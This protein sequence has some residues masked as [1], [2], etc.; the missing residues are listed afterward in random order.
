MICGLVQGEE[1]KSRWMEG[2]C[3]E[4]VGA[5][6]NSLISYNSCNF[7]VI[8]K[9][10]IQIILVILRFHGSLS[11]PTTDPIHI[12]KTRSP[13]DAR[14][15]PIISYSSTSNKL[16]LFGGYSDDG[17]ENDIWTFSLTSFQWFSAYQLSTLSPGI[18]YSD[19]RSSGAGFSSTLTSKFYIF[20]GVTTNGVLNDFWEFHLTS[21]KWTHIHTSNQPSPRKLF[22]F[23]N[24]DD[25]KNEYL[26]IYGGTTISGTNNDLYM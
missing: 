22:A 16:V 12:P 2:R 25:G 21:R 8:M 20:A 4:D 1:V 13:P 23:C 26:A 9:K 17:F 15:E 18:L 11:V 10:L 6:S 7:L 24:F 19:P 3:G 5:M 14:A